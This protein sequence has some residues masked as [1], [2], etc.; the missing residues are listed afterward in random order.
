MENGAFIQQLDGLLGDSCANGVERNL[1]ICTDEE[2]DIKDLK[3]AIDGNQATP[4][5]VVHMA[6]KTYDR[7][8]GIIA[9]DFANELN[10]D[11]IKQLRK[12]TYMPSRPKLYDIT[13]KETR[14]LKFIK[15]NNWCDFFYQSLTTCRLN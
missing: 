3:S 11:V 8:Y 10:D 5:E 1:V 7:I 4:E 9:S 14:F 12:S 15:T 13:N 6:N 2:W